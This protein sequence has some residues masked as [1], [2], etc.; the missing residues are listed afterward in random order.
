MVERKLAQNLQFGA[1]TVYKHHA[2]LSKRTSHVEKARRSRP[3]GPFSGGRGPVCV[4]R[5][6]LGGA[7]L[8]DQPHHGQDVARRVD[9]PLQQPARAPLLLPGPEFGGAACA[10]AWFMPT[11]LTKAVKPIAAAVCQSV[12]RVRC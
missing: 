7:P 8:P 11:A 2:N 6:P 9:H 12:R 1:V 5:H 4:A 3:L 10:Q